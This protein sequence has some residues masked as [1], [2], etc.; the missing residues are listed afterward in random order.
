MPLVVLQLPCLIGN[1]VNGKRG[2][3]REDGDVQN[4]SRDCVPCWVISSGR[5]FFHDY[6][7]I[8]LCSCHVVTMDET[9]SFGKLFLRFG[10]KVACLGGRGKPEKVLGNNLFMRGLSSSLSSE[11]PESVLSSAAPQL[12][13]SS[14]P[15]VSSFLVAPVVPSLQD[16][17]PALGCS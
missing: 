1:K 17:C 15:L 2:K 11:G 6:L 3:Q 4:S 8:V 13:Q 10:R 14:S 7:V 9:F 16:N 12:Q 5:G